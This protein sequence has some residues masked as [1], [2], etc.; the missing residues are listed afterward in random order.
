MRVL[1]KTIDD[2]FNEKVPYIILDSP[3]HGMEV[4]VTEKSTKRKRTVDDDE[5][6]LIF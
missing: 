6:L 5:R 3:S 1:T 4:H 2:I